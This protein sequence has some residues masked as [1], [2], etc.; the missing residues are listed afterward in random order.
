[1]PA[2]NSVILGAIAIGL[3]TVA[4]L[5]GAKVVALLNNIGVVV[6]LVASVFLIIFF[7]AAAVRGPQVILR[8]E[9]HATG[10]SLGVPGALPGL[11]PPGRGR[12]RRG[13]HPDGAA[14]AARC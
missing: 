4:N 2:T 11:V 7:F 3:T 10:S 1:M 5:F 12:T 6:E 8:T 13:C 9:G 14:P